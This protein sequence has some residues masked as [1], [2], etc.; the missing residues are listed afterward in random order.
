MTTSEQQSAQYCYRH[1]DSQT[2]LR[3]SRCD[4]PICTK[5]ARSTQVGYRC[6]DCI[7]ELES[8]T[9]KGGSY[10]DPLSAPRTEPLVTYVIMAILVIAW[11][12]QELIG[13]ST[14]NDTL[15][16]LGSTEK[17]HFYLQY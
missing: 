14:D 9:I 1:A 2:N 3:C 16:F 15:I 13:G 7:Y 17:K 11:V 5:C 6:P 8:R 12:V 4:N 10:V